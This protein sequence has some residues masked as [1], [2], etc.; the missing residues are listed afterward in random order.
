MNGQSF[1][2]LSAE[3]TLLALA[4]A[5][6]PAGHHLPTANGDLTLR[7]REVLEHFG[8][9][10]FFGYRALLAALELVSVALAGRRLSK[11]PVE[12]RRDVLER[13]ARGQA[14][15]LVRAAAAPIK[16]ARAMNPE[17]RGALGVPELRR[18]QLAPQTERWEQRLS[19]ARELDEDETLEVDAV[20]VG[21]GAGGAPVA[22]QLASRGHAV[23]ILEEGGHHKRSDFH[24]TPL[25]MQ[26]RLYR[27]GGA[28]FALGNT[29]MPVPIGCG[30]GG[31][32]TVNAGTCY[33]V[34]TSVQHR[35]QLELGLH[36]LGPGALDEHYERVEE[37]LQVGPSDDDVL[38]GCARVIARGCE[39]LGYRHGALRRNA[40][41]CDGQGL[42]VFGCPTEAKRSTD[43]SYLPAALK[44]GA[45]LF[46]HARVTEILRDGSGRACGVVAEAVRDDGV[47]RRLTVRASAV[48][49]AC[50][51]LHTPA[52]LFSNGLGN[53]SGQLGRN[54]SLHPASYAW[55]L[56]DEQIAGWNAVPQGYAV[57]E[58]VDQGLHFE[59]AFVPFEFAAGAFPFVGERWIRVVEQLDRMAC[60]GFMLSDSALGRVR[61]VGGQPR[62]VYRLA[63]RDRLQAIRA[64]G[65]L[66]RIF[67]A[68][69]AHAVYPGLRTF[70]ELRSIADVEQ[71]EREGPERLRARDIDLTAYHPLGTCRLGRD[72]SRS[73]CGPNH[74]C[75]EVEGLFVCDGSAVPG[76]LGVN[77][78]MTIMAMSERASAFVEQHIEQ[79][80]RRAARDAPLRAV[81]VAAGGWRLEF[82]ETMTGSCRFVDESIDRAVRFRVRAAQHSPQVRRLW[83]ERSSELSLRGTLSL[84]GVATEVPCRGTLRIAPLRSRATVHYEL[85]FAADDGTPLRLRGDKNVRPGALVRGMTTLHTEILHADRDELLARGILR[86]DLRDVGD[87][88]SSFRLRS[89]PPQGPRERPVGPS[90]STSD[91]AEL[92]DPV[93]AAVGR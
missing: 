80:A 76:P 64:H 56:F 52:L 60:F 62:I 1:L 18:P 71:L 46:H 6:A 10:G 16:V 57:T 74:E 72:P 67:F 78:Q 22:H 87:F 69:G 91:S 14:F 35:W 41:G 55:A 7:V 11:L 70:D 58:F 92:L 8:P 44:R 40:P 32:T 85:R 27:D 26:R 50:G 81:A 28:T 25:Q 47:R 4:E 89:G 43:V 29:F 49:L 38:G 63:D 31:T 30:V 61:M 5:V 2:M 77:P 45:M 51:A 48:V 66:A 90:A 21:S 59:G 34:P 17:L 84:D 75:H 65:I 88:V 12:R 19:D 24:G 86:F 73:V 83:D 93:E 23:L 13:L 15:W 20:I 36:Q 9:R 53:G 3:A 42:C 54:L 37:M 33:R 82:D 79:R 39:A 68:A